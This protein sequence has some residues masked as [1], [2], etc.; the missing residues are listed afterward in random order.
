HSEVTAL[1]STHAGLPALHILPSSARDERTGRVG[2]HGPDRLNEALPVAQRHPELLEIALCQL[3][4]HIAVDRVLDECR[5]ISSEPQVSQPTANVHGSALIR[6]RVIMVKKRVEYM[7]NPVWWTPKHGV[8]AAQ[9]T[10]RNRR[11]RHSSDGLQERLHHQKFR[12]NRSI[13]PEGQ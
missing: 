13:A 9:D 11:N 2:E 8:Q 10:R 6:S 3:R 7:V 12:Q 4:Q 5:L 1:G